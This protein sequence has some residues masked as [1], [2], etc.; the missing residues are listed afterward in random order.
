[1]L[2]PLV[3]HLTLDTSP[4]DSPTLSP[5]LSFFA[6]YMLQVAGLSAMLYQLWTKQKYYFWESKHLPSQY[7]QKLHISYFTWCEIPITLLSIQIEI[8]SLNKNSTLFA[9]PA[10]FK[11]SYTHTYIASTH[12]PLAE[13][14]PVLLPIDNVS[15]NS[16]LRGSQW[17][18]WADISVSCPSC[19]CLKGPADCRSVC[20]YT[21]LSCNYLVWAVSLIS[22]HHY[23]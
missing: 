11:N 6:L 9:N 2:C 15:D 14:W 19:G 4:A 10:P 8:L 5:F 17:A 3:K 16:D 23:Q 12:M 13:P 7:L 1:M 21:H 18:F 22:G 20:V